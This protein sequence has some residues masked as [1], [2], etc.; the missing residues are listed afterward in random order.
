LSG[1]I[2]KKIAY[3]TALSRNPTSNVRSPTF[4]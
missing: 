4:G 2:E 3:R 1:L